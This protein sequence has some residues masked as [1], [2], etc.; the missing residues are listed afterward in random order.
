MKPRR[1][2]K[3]TSSKSIRQPVAAKPDFVMLLA[4]PEIRLLM[5]ADNVNES[6]LLRML[7]SVS[8]RLRKDNTKDRKGPGYR[9]TNTE[10]RK[11]RRGVGVLLINGKNEIFIARRIDVGDAWQMPQGGI[12]SRESAEQAAFRELK[13]EIGTNNATIIALSRGWFYYDVPEDIAKKAWGGR[14]KGQRQKWF[15]MRFN[16]TDAEIN[17]ATEHPEFDAWRWTSIAE[18]RSLAVTFKRDLY[19]SL[20][21]EFSAILSHVPHDGDEGFVS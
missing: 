3:V 4:E 10:A 20:L 5:R 15:V 12:D 19:A 7:G 6:E 21:E 14:W 16:G 13:E 11:Y 9:V 18:L 2:T 17:L 1:R 8:V